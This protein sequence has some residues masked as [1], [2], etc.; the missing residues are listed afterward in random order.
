ME[1]LMFGRRLLATLFVVTTWGCSI[2]EIP[3]PFP[4]EQPYGSVVR[5]IRIEGNR[6]T[7]SSIVRRAMASKVGEPY[8]RETARVDYLWLSQLGTFTSIGFLTEPV[9]D[10][11][12]LVVSVEEATPYV[13]SVSLA[14]TQENGIEIGPAFES[15]NL[16]GWAT[17][18]TVYARFGGATN[19][20]ASFRDPWL[21]G[22]NWLFGY[23][24]EYFHRERR[25]ELDN[26]DEKSDEFALRL[27]RNITNA[28]RFGLRASYVSL[29]SDSAD[30]TLS[31][32]NRDKIPGLGLFVELDTRNAAYPTRGWLTE[33]EIAK[34]GILGGD[35]DYWRFTGDVRRYHPL[36]LGPRHSLAFYSLVTLTSGEV[37]VDI[38]IHQDFHIGGTNSVRG[39][40]LGSRVGKNQWLNTLEYWFV[41]S[42]EKAIRLWFLKW[43]MGLQLGVFGDVGT[44]WN[45]SQEFGDNFIAGFGAGVRLTLPVMV[46]IRMDLGYSQR[47]FGL[48]FH[49]GGSEKAH[50][51]R[52]RVR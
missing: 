47:Q 49:I 31:P 39:W 32:D 8:T 5:E 44:A 29:A 43:R 6:H 13:P 52:Q 48:K 14:L 10:G 4:A 21:P 25:N 20:G 40:P 37:G 35:G 50:A 12:V 19:F 16:F 11:I 34:Y 46:L 15:P 51:Q 38:P 17:R 45:T 22:K 33:L 27:R 24:L 28:V 41:L 9:D 42:Q 3:A 7:S 26:F 18:A 1:V 2:K 23:D 30:I 36:P